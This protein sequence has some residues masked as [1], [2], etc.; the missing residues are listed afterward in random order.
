M[1]AE[2]KKMMKEAVL[3]ALKEMDLINI[4]NQN[5]DVNK[6]MDPYE[7]SEYLDISRTYIY[8]HQDEIPHFKMGTKLRFNK[9]DIDLW[10]RSEVKNKKVVR[11][12]II[13]RPKRTGN[14]MFVVD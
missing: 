8:A 2:F 1:E 10:K 3:D 9:A 13:V 14:S 12:E 4:I 11:S 6:V 7:L 5:K